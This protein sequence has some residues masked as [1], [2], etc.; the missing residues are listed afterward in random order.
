MI[1]VDLMDKV[2]CVEMKIYEWERERVELGS[3]GLTTSRGSYSLLLVIGRVKKFPN[4]VEI[5]CTH[6]TIHTNFEIY[7]VFKGTVFLGLN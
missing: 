5:P 2:Y 4:P 1:N 7:P 3:A 6:C